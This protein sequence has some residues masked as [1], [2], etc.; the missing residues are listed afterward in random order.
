MMSKV[1]AVPC[2]VYSRVVGYYRPI[3]D[4]N[5]G[6][7]EEYGDRYQ[8]GLDDL[9]PNLMEVGS[10]NNRQENQETRVTLLA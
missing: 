10:A 7:K 6:K 5:R 1:C 3:Q 2:E 4:W 8:M 9:A